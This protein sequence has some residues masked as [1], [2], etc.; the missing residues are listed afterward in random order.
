VPGAEIASTRLASASSVGLSA[1]RLEAI[2]IRTG[3]GS[4][5]GFV[6]SEAPLPGEQLTGNRSREVLFRGVF[7]CGAPL[8]LCQRAASKHHTA[9]TVRAHREHLTLHAWNYYRVVMAQPRTATA[10]RLPDKMHEELKKAAED[11]GLSVNFLVVVA[12]EEMLSRLAPAE[13]FRGSLLR[14]G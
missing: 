8:A 2:P 6:R 13:E 14:A 11:R 1:A 5:Q 7:V 12:V 3:P 9:R 10:I 4:S